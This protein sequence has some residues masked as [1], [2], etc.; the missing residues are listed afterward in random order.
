MDDI[1][2]INWLFSYEVIRA[3]VDL[4][5]FLKKLCARKAER[6]EAAM[7]EAVEA[8][9]IFFFREGGCGCGVAGIDSC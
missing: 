8:R 9:R 3:Q 4:A 1:R 2:D 7:R 5:R 6:V